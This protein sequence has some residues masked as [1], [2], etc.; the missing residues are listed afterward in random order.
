[1]GGIFV[2][3]KIK[4]SRHRSHRKASF[5]LFYPPVS[6]GHLG[7]KRIDR[8]K[9]VYILKDACRV[10]TKTAKIQ[11]GSQRP[12]EQNIFLANNPIIDCDMS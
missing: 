2:E 6:S 12:F 4:N 5:Y 10:W 1:M 7:G 11:D 3:R 8:G 9:P